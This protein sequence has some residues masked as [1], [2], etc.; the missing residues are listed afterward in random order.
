L[1]IVTSLVGLLVYLGFAYFLRIEELAEYFSLIKKLG[2]WR[3]VLRESE[4]VIEVTP[5]RGQTLS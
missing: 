3:Q 4:E 2:K 5:S 1:T